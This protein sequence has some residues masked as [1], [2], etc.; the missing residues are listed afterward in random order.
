MQPYSSTP[1]SSS[2]QDY[3][4]TSSTA[5]N[6]PRRSPRLTHA[7]FDSTGHTS[8]ALNLRSSADLSSPWIDTPDNIPLPS[9]HEN[10][11]LR[12][13]AVRPGSGSLPSP[14]GISGMLRTDVG[15]SRV[16]SDQ[17]FNPTDASRSGRLPSPRAIDGV[18]PPPNVGASRVSLGG[19]LPST[20]VP[21]AVSVLD[22]V[23]ASRGQIV[24]TTTAQH[25][26][27][28]EI[29]TLGLGHE[30]YDSMR[31]NYAQPSPWPGSSPHQATASGE[32]RATPT[33]PRRDFNSYARDGDHGSPSLSPLDAHLVPRLTLLLDASPTHATTTETLSHVRGILGQYGLRTFSPKRH[34]QSFTAE[35]A[36]YVTWAQLLVDFRTSQ[37]RLDDLDPDMR[38]NLLCFGTITPS[39]AELDPPTTAMAQFQTMWATPLEVAA[40]LPEATWMSL[41]VDALRALLGIMGYD[42][43]L[44]RVTH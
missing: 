15:A 39:T 41:K 3:R 17:A 8:D 4:L 18:M 10:S 21:T 16:S 7:A 11:G 27:E 28:I 32:P 13:L 30:G 31:A 33:A 5:G 9:D 22:Q 44:S 2:V 40:T 19:A 6:G 14:R 25:V 43:R 38:R 20:L 42:Q 34:G 29:D 26:T 36:D 35:V 12:H 24:G 1:S 37:L 23:S